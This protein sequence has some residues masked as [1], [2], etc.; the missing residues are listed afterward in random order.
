M[1]SIVVQHPEVLVGIAPDGAPEV[2][3]APQQSKQQDKAK[4]TKKKNVD[5]APVDEPAPAVSLDIVEDATLRSLE[6]LKAQYGD[7]LRIAVDSERTFVG[8]T[9]SHIRV[10]RLYAR[11][12]QLFIAIS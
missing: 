9:G 8:I 6:D 11:Y 7:A 4:K 3:I 12:M 5:V 1:W 10:S 2:Y